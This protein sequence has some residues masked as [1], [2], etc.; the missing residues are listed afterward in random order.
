MR[1]LPALLWSLIVVGA[2]SLA[3]AR[4]GD[5]PAV[6]GVGGGVAF[7]VATSGHLV[8]PARINGRDVH[9]VVDTGAGAS[10][11]D[12]TAAGALGVVAMD[13][14]GGRAIGAGG[15]D[16]AIQRSTGNRVELAGTAND[17]VELRIMELGHVVEALSTPTRPIVGVIGFDWLDRHR[18]VID[19]AQRTM[20]A[21]R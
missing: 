5:A 1:I 9:L 12:R 17:D 14:E 16:I 3:H 8:V 21:T 6:A 18:V 11:I 19:Y 7:E 4:N 15:K 10:I 20:T 2:S 13:G